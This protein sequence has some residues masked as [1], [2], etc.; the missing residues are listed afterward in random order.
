MMNR[1]AFNI[2]LFHVPKAAQHDIPFVHTKPTPHR[3]ADRLRLLVDL[4]EHEVL[5]AAPFDLRKLKRN[6]LDGLLHRDVLDGHR[7]EAIAR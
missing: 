4:L 6:F 2:L 5:V 1:R 7:A 3:I